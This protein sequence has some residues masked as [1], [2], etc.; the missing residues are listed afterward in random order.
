MFPIFH[1]MLAAILGTGASA[2]PAPH[3]P[4]D[5]KRSTLPVVTYGASALGQPAGGVEES[6]NRN[7]KLKT[8]LKA[9]KHLKT[10]KDMKL[11]K[12]TDKDVKLKSWSGKTGI[13][14]K[15]TSTE[16]KVQQ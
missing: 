3:V 10:N 12:S 4:S 8:D 15:D 1:A 14:I 13:D 11:T 9:N 6:I 5:A 16:K 2:A 7:V